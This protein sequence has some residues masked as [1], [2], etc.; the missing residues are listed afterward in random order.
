[1]KQERNP[2]FSEVVDIW[3]NDDIVSKMLEPLDECEKKIQTTSWIETS[4]A[5]IKTLFEIPMRSFQEAAQVFV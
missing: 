5:F 2:R 1:M 3:W 4:Q